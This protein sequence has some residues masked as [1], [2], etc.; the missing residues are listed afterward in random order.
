[1]GIVLDSSVLIA[2]ERKGE[3]ARQVM[4]EI[5][6]KTGNTDA[7]LSVNLF[8][9]T[10]TRRG[11]CGYPGTKAAARANDPGIAGGA[12]DISDHARHSVTSRSNRRR[13][14]SERCLCATRRFADWSHCPG[15]RLFSSDREPA[16]LSTDSRAVPYANVAAGEQTR[17]HSCPKPLELPAWTRARGLALGGRRESHD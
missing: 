1:M 2:A 16:P 7:A 4:S 10:R 13:Q 12:A 17:P 11:P 3:N 6:R 8:D 15:N 14:P 5:L 9:R